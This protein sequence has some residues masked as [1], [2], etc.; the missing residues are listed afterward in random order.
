MRNKFSDL[1][2]SGVADFKYTNI[3]TNNQDPLCAEYN[4]LYSISTDTHMAPYEDGYIITG[5]LRGDDY[6]KLLSICDSGRSYGYYSI[7][8]FFSA[9]GLKGQFGI[10]NND[11]VYILTI[12]SGEDE[13]ATADYL[14]KDRYF[15]CNSNIPRPFKELSTD[16]DARKV[17]E[18]FDGN[19][20]EV[21]ENLN[22]SMYVKGHY[23][24]YNNTIYGMVDGKHIMI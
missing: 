9:H 8:H 21:V 3:V 18:C 14:K 2:K 11:K 10:V 5:H 17:L 20:Q 24:H 16:G 1:I 23:F 12:D 15:E 22:N 13:Y 19:I 7:S 4:N 6:D